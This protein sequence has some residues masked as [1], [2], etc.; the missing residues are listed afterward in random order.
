MLGVGCLA[1]SAIVPSTLVVYTAETPAAVLWRRPKAAS[2][3]LDGMAADTA[4][5]YNP[6][7]EWQITGP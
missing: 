6:P 1:I 4:K 7:L 3:L 2:T 5:L